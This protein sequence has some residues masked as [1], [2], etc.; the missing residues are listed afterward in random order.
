MFSYS[1]ILAT[2]CYYFNFT[3]DVQWSYCRPNID[4]M[5]VFIVIP[6]VMVKSIE[7]GNG[8]QMT[9]TA[10]RENAMSR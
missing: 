10:H 8:R 4:E 9:N 2:L 7:R 1:S 6:E 3:L 5:H